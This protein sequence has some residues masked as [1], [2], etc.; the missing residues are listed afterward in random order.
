MKTYSGQ[1]LDA[2]I[3]KFLAKRTERFPELRNKKPMTQE[4]V[5]ENR[6]LQSLEKASLL[7]TRYIHA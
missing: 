2:K 5:Y 1:E 4:S 7:W 6:F 3:N